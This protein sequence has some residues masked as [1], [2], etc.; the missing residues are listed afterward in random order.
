MKLLSLAAF[1]YAINLP[2]GVW[3]KRLNGFSVPWVLAMH[4]VVGLIVLLRHFLHI[5]ASLFFL[6]LGAGVLGQYTGRRLGLPRPSTQT[7]N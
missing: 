7:D 6:S 4:A 2:M 1:A 3:R 5:K